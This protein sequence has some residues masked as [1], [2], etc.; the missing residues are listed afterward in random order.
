[1]HITNPNDRD[2]P[3]TVTFFTNQGREVRT[4]SVVPARAHRTIHVEDFVPNLGVEGIRVSTVIVS[5][6]NLPLAIERS[7][8]LGPGHD[9]G[10]GGT[11]VD[12]LS[13]DW[14]FAEGANIPSSFMATSY[15]LFNPTATRATITLTFLLGEG[16]APVQRTFDLL[17]GEQR[18]ILDAQFP[19]LI[20]HTFGAVVHASQP[21][22]ADREMFFATGSSPVPPLYPGLLRHGGRAGAVDAVVL[23]GRRHRSDVRCLPARRESAGHGAGAG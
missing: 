1:M 11:A 6:A 15:T 16:A 10:L 13:T 20:G 19:E 4:A 14:L 17:A 18:V 5:D 22:A 7:Q 8:Y 12:Q 21:I 3:V 9:T 23:R 2:A